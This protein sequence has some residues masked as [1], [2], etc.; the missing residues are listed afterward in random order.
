MGEAQGHLHRQ[1]DGGLHQARGPR[2]PGV[3]RF[4]LAFAR[5]FVLVARFYVPASLAPALARVEAPVMSFR[6]VSF[7][8]FTC[9]ERSSTSRAVRTPRRPRDLETRS[10]NTCSSLS[11]LPPP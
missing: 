6:T 5:A 1:G 2:H 11:H 9:R 4:A 3:A 10:S 7:R 8:S